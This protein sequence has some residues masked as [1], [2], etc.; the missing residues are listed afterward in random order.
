MAPHRDTTGAAL[1]T[2]AGGERMSTKKKSNDMTTDDESLIESLL[3]G[4]GPFIRKLRALS[5]ELDEQLNETDEEI[6]RRIQEGEPSRPRI[7]WDVKVRTLA[8]GE[9]P[10]VVA[11]S[12]PR[13]PRVIEPRMEIFDEVDRL[14]VVAEVPGV[15]EE[16]IQCEV[17]GTDF[18]LTT[19]EGCRRRYHATAPL[20]RPARITAR[21]VTNGILEVELMTDDSGDR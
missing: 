8:D 3:P 5:P 4:L 11:P 13:P 20:P 18:V 2:T 14:L 17:D 1:L 6:R 21:H 10:R 19:Q 7:A 9:A 15:T 12:H 16:E